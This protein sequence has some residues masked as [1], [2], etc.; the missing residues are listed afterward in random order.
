MISNEMLFTSQSIDIL[1]GLGL[2]AP[3]GLRMIKPIH[4]K[5]FMDNV[6]PYGDVVFVQLQLQICHTLYS[7]KDSVAHP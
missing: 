1:E 4:D 6:T 5:Q 7:A 3:L 2:F